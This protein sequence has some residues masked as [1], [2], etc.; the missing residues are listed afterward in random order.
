MTNEGRHKKIKPFKHKYQG[1]DRSAGLL[2]AV[3]EKWMAEAEIERRR[4]RAKNSKKTAVE[5]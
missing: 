3:R 4:L 5:F 2:A 1:V